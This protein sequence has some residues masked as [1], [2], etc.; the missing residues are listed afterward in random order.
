MRLCLVLMIPAFCLAAC[1]GCEPA[2]PDVTVGVGVGT[3][4]THSDLSVGQ[5][6]GPMHV[7]VGT[8]GMGLAL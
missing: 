3:S 1:T 6:C 4:G 5:S 8:G 7:R 2:R